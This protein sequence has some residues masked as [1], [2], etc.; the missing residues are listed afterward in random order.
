M[1]PVDDYGD[2]FKHLH[3]PQQPEII[4]DVFINI[5]FWIKKLLHC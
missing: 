1:L 5:L 2:G 3:L 4:R